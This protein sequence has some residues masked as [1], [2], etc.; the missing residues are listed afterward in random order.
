MTQTT[1]LVVPSMQFIL[2]RHLNGSRT[3]RQ[4]CRRH[5]LL[6]A[7]LDGLAGRGLALH[8]CQRAAWKKC[9]R[10]PKIHTGF[11]RE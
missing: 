3:T 1:A 8:Q 2:A 11:I 5:Y 7:G 9:S 10:S 4:M 6:G